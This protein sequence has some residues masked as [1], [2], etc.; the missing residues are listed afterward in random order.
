MSNLPAPGVYSV[1]PPTRP[2]ASSLAT[3]SRE[4]PWKLH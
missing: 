1:D 4:G 3:S 2:S